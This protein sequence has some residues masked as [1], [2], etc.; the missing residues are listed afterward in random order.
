MQKRCGMTH[1]S[2]MKL[3]FSML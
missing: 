3:T 2:V 1:K